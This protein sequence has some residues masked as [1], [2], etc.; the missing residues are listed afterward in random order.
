M[1][2]R[3][4][5]IERTFAHLYDTGGLRR[6]HLRGK[7][8]LAKRLLIHAAA[9]NLSL[10]LRQLL[11]V[12]TAR[13]AAELLT[14]LC[15]CI[16]RL[17]HAANRGP[18]VIGP[19]WPT[20]RRAHP[21]RCG[22]RSA[23]PSQRGFIHGLDMTARRAGNPPAATA[24]ASALTSPTPPG[25]RPAGATGPAD[26]TGEPC[27]G[28]SAH[29]R[30]WIGIATFSM[31]RQAHPCTAPGQDPLRTFWAL[32]EDSL[33]DPKRLATPCAPAAINRN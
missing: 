23:Q 20:A 28:N 9:F 2:R 25:T 8:N 14:A 11:G 4:V 17:M 19:R 29:F 32:P 3:G 13:Q 22:H 6:V 5:L 33:P 26:G 21:P 27:G 7:D 30:I 16:L 31:A 18:L 10:I 1:R 15:F 24:R 12:G